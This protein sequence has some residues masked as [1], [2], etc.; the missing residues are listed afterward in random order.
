MAPSTR[1]AFLGQ[2]AR[3]A[4]ALGAL[5]L[6]IPAWAGAKVRRAQDRVAL[7]R[8]GITVSRL[9]Q[10]TGAFDARKASKPPLD[11]AGV[12][13]LL[14]AGVEQGLD[15]WDL[16]DAYGTHPAAREALERVRRDRVVLMT[17]SWSRDAASMRADLERFRRELGVEQLDLVLLHCLTDANW[18]KTA[19]GAM[20]ALAEAKQ[21][22]IIRGHGISCHSLAALE[23]ATTSKWVD[24][25]LA[26]LNPVGAMMDTDAEDVVPVL[27]KLKSQG[28]GIVGMKI[29]GAGQLRKRIDEA[30]A[31]AVRSP[32]LDAFTI[33]AAN[34]AELRD[35]I[36][37]IAKVKT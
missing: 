4:T 22:G 34:Q 2:S 19:A 32:V 9:A 21:K 36:E 7:G 27:A 37:R 26:R 30:L 31:Y 14:E 24:V 29:L 5:A 16:A 33:G 1:R 8:S 17:K 11:T 6:P 23:H 28:K 20:E 25:V 35:L 10:G 12:A 18:T 15:F 3:A 13:A